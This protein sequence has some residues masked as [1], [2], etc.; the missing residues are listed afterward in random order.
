MHAT[1][2]GYVQ[3]NTGGISSTRPHDWRLVAVGYTSEMCRLRVDKWIRE[4]NRHQS[5]P[6]TYH[7]HITEETK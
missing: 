5:N 6:C 1:F 3:L 4:V 2:K 7:I